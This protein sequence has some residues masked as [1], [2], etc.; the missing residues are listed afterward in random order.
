MVSAGDIMNFVSERVAS[1]KRIRRVEFVDQI[2]K[3]PTG[4]IM[5]R[6]LVERVRQSIR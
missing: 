6:V 5:R 3:N 4:K 2:P 1:H